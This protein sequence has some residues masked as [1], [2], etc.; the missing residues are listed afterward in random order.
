MR[1]LHIDSSITGNLSVSRQLTA[2]T[3]AAWMTLHPGAEVQYLDL[4]SLAV[5]H[6]GGTSLGFGGAHSSITNV[7]RRENLL[8]EALL[9]QFL[10]ADVVVVG[11]PMYNFSIPTQL[12]AW[13][14]RVAQVGRTFYYTEQGAKGLAGGKSVIVVLT[15]GG[16]Y[17][18]SEEGRA[19]EHQQSYLQT[20]FNF[21]GITDVRFLLVEGVAMGSSAKATALASA[22]RNI[23]R[24]VGNPSAQS[25]GAIPCP[26]SQIDCPRSRALCVLDAGLI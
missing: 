9:S 7:Q 3:V 13:I 19:M 18:T 20:V 24:L 1:M 6:L 8:T 16:V 23:Q 21:F 11:A 25:R 2:R 22:E 12:K 14:D 10:E 26:P 4:A 17:S 5:P 15:R